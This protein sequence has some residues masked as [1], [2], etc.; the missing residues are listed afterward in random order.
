MLFPGDAV[1]DQLREDKETAESQVCISFL[2]SWI[3]PIKGLAQVEDFFHSYIQCKDASL[4]WPINFSGLT[5]TNLHLHIWGSRTEAVLLNAA[6][7]MT[8]LLTQT[9]TNK[10][11]FRCSSRLWSLKFTVDSCSCYSIMFYRGE[12]W[13]LNLFEISLK[14]Y[15]ASDI[16]TWPQLLQ[17]WLTW[18]MNRCH[19][20]TVLEHFTHSGE[21][22][23][24]VILLRTFLPLTSSLCF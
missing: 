20:C 13:G 6:C 8:V 22:I 17:G 7:E 9:F 18:L 12:I 5:I 19:S 23:A 3:M 16:I 15:W 2:S 14:A 21:M 1:L 4:P 10:Y 24:R 11:Y